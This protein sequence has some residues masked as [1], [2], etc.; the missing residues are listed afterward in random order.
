MFFGLIASFLFVITSCNSNN[1]KEKKKKDVGIAVGSLSK[2]NNT[3]LSIS[4]ADAAKL[5]QKYNRLTTATIKYTYTRAW[6]ET[7]QIEQNKYNYYLA[8]EASLESENNQK[9]YS[10]YSIFTELVVNANQ[11]Y[12]YPRGTQHSCTSKCC[13]SCKLVLFKNSIGCDCD[14][15]SDSTDCN[16]NVRCRHSVSKLLDVQQKINS[17]I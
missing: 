12:F 7:I 8:L 10:S 6:I 5:M 11:L 9:V 1:K 15:P 13:S 3:K 14:T 17:I 4:L 2:S 16:N